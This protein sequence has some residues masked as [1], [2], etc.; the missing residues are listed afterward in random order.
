M[1]GIKLLEFEQFICIPI[2]PLEYLNLNINSAIFHFRSGNEKKI[3][4]DNSDDDNDD[5][6]DDEDDD[7]SHYSGFNTPVRKTLK[8]AIEIPNFEEWEKERLQRWDAWDFSNKE[9]VSD[10][11][12][13]H[14][15]DSY[16]RES[17]SSSEID[18]DFDPY[19]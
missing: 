11:D 18:G 13:S 12:S 7:D 8:S 1:I 10:T 16:Y 9:E 17:Y 3:D 5:D 4:V 2:C 19:A 6:D 15:S 14:D